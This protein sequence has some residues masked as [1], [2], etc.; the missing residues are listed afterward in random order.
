MTNFVNNSSG[1]LVY[2]I[3]QSNGLQKWT[4]AVIAT[5]N[6]D[7]TT[8]DFDFGNPGV[9]KKVY[10]V[11]ITHKGTGT[12]PTPY[13]DVNGETSLNKTFTETLGSSSSWTTT[14]L[15]PSTSSQANNIYSFQLKI[16]GSMGTDFEINDISIV[17]RLKPVK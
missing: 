5:S 1:D 8:K 17:Y 10:K 2:A 6:Y 15:T 4:E 12:R 16:S 13:F 7:V 9:R 3:D 11:Y 14:S